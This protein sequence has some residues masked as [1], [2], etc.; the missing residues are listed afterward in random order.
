MVDGIWFCSR[1]CVE[2]EAST[3]LE[4]VRVR[5]RTSRP[6]ARRLGTVLLERRTI[7]PI[8]LGRALEAQRETGLR[9]GAQL[10]RMG[11][12][13]RDE[14]LRALSAQHGVSYL[15]A[16]DTGTLRSAPGKLSA[17]EVRTLG[18]IPFRE[19]AEALMV[20]CA[21]P[22]PQAALDALG[23]LSGRT[24]HPF[25]VADDD[26]ERLNAAY[27]GA[28]DAAVRTPTVRVA[29]D[30]TR[31]A[32][33]PDGGEAAAKTPY[34]DPFTWVRIAADGHISTLLVPPPSQQREEHDVW[35]AATTRH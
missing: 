11:F 4:D 1:A 6:A 12:A 26:F 5:Q 30:G 10:Q 17:D 8:Q 33:R 2:A 27:R 7:T 23:V 20:A 16:I 13:N 9:L 22:L 21:A 29:P 34:A 15:A 28:V 24:I 19:T 25:L 18:I 32:G 3:K 14:V 35:L 31:D